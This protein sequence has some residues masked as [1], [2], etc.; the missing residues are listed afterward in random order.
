[1]Y[2]ARILYPIKVLGPGNRIGIWMAGC[3]HRCKGCSNPELWEFHEKYKTSLQTVLTL[4]EQIAKDN[5]IEGFTI[6]GGDPFEQPDAL[7]ELIFQLRKYNSDILVYTG[8]EYE[9]IQKKYADTLAL[10]SVLIDGKY[11]EGK[12]NASC[13]IGSDNQKICYI[14]ENVKHKY[15]CYIK[16]NHNQIQNFTS[17]DGIISVGIHRPDYQQ[18]LERA[19][20]RKGLAEVA[21]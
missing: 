12:N 14:D 1:M 20:R 11:E 15:R 16:E 17:K 7:K 4:V 21:E 19:I 13:L 5:V 10:I 6:T 3:K 18:E 9:I 2:V 8:Y